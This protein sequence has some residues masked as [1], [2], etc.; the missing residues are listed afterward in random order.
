MSVDGHIDFHL[1]C[2]LDIESRSQHR[3]AKQAFAFY[4]KTCADC[5]QGDKR[6]G[7]QSAA[8]S[9]GRIIRDAGPARPA[10]SALQPRPPVCT[11]QDSTV[12]QRTAQKAAMCSAAG[13]HGENLQEEQLPQG[14]AGDRRLP[15]VEETRYDHRCRSIARDGPSYLKQRLGAAEADST[16]MQER[17]PAS[18]QRRMTSSPMRNRRRRRRPMIHCGMGRCATLAMPMNAGR[19]ACWCISRA[20]GCKTL[21]NGPV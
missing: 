20:A 11:D 12:G 15:A 14:R 10:G 8:K 16:L 13:H 1:L 21:L 2:P 7:K 5:T 17:S 4:C 6:P 19:T 9:K 3:L 18:P